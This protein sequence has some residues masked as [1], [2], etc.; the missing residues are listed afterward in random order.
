MDIS[1]NIKL[2]P[3]LRWGVLR[4]IAT[5]ISSLSILYTLIL[6]I[7][8]LV[9][10]SLGSKLV[11]QKVP[12]IFFLSLFP[13]IFAF[14]YFYIY[15]KEENKNGKKAKF[16]P[17]D[18]QQLAEQN[19]IN[20]GLLQKIKNRVHCDFIQYEDSRD[21][22]PR[23]I[24]GYIAI[25][26]IYVTDVFKIVAEVISFFT[27]YQVLKSSINFEDVLLI[28]YANKK[29]D[30]IKDFGLFGNDHDIS[31]KVIFHQ[32]TEWDRKYGIILTGI[33]TDWIEF[34]INAT[35]GHGDTIVNEI[36]TLCP[37]TMEQGY[38]S[39]ELL[40]KELLQGNPIFLWWD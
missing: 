23:K 10:G 17:E 32:F 6:S 38:N 33:S 1:R 5:K 21:D 37:D 9:L 11:G 35:H 13:G 25:V 15:V 2:S 8:I 40:R 34:K 12:D 19:N 4:N 18:I 24:R 7:S 14:L 20:I 3:S 39:K 30:I 26:N 27:E 36:I 29:L 28:T 31:T 22:P 16:K